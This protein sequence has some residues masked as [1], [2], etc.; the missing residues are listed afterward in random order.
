MVKQN[1][2]FIQLHT[3]DNVVVAIEDIRKGSSLTIEKREIILSQE[4]KLGH[5]IAIKEI[6]K[7]DKII[8]CGTSIGSATE[9]IRPGNL[10]H[11]HN[12]KSDYIPTYTLKDPYYG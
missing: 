12:M 3:E 7:G 10:V 4:I 11:L 5:K 9:A 6:S 2:F 1:H 8:K